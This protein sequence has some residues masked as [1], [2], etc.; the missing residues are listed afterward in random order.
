MSTAFQTGIAPPAAPVA[1]LENI[2]DHSFKPRDPQRE[3]FAPPPPEILPLVTADSTLKY[4]KNPISLPVRLILVL[5]SAAVLGAGPILLFQNDRN[6]R[7][8]GN[9]LGLIFGIGA[10]IVIWFLTRFSHQCTY[11]GQNGLC[12]YRLKASRTAVPTIEALRFPE[13][14][15]LHAS[16]TRHYTN[17]VYTGTSYSY[18][19][20]GPDG[21][22]LFVISGRYSSKNGTP[23]QGDAFYFARAAEIAWSEFYLAYADYQLQREGAIAFRVDQSR[24]LRVGPGFL[25]FHFGGPP[26]RVEKADIAKV[27]LG[28]GTF[29]FKHKDARWFSSEGK[30]SFQYGKMANAKVFLLALDKLLGYRWS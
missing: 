27:T 10:P 3:F 24:V 1:G 5:A 25:E 29:S 12:R 26:A 18:D 8:M 19:W 22:K 7:D 21:R 28:G 15:E 14:A 11:V 13:A 30:Y 6:A 4:G 23:K 9:T 2:P 17:G 20:T 16:Q